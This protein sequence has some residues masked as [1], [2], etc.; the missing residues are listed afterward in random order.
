MFY[1]DQKVICIKTHSQSNIN[2]V[3]K[4]KVFIVEACKKSD[5]KCAEYTIDI[6]LESN[7]ERSTVSRC[8][9]CKTHVFNDGIWWLNAALFAPLSDMQTELSETTVESILEH[10]LEKV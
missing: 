5:C 7:D 1:P 6:G 8:R 3:I 2:G 4:G 10:E 9:I